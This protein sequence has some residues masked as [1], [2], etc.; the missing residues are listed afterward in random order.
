MLEKHFGISQGVL[1]LYDGSR[2]CFVPRAYTGLD[3][4]TRHRMLIPRTF[5]ED[6][7][8]LTKPGA[9]S[10]EKAPFLRPFFSIRQWSAVQS[11]SWI[12]LYYR[13]YCY[14][15]LL[16][17]EAEGMGQQR[18]QRGLEK[19][20]K[21]CSPR[22]F[23][24]RVAPLMKLKSPDK[25]RIRDM[26]G[27]AQDLEELAAESYTLLC[28][29]TECVALLQEN[30]VESEPYQCKNDILEVISSMTGSAVSVLDLP[31]MQILLIYPDGFPAKPP[32]LLHQF[33]LALERFFKKEGFKL[34]LGETANAYSPG[35]LDKH[36]IFQNLYQ[37]DRGE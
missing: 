22:V 15:L 21:G 23:L 26:K 11:L 37:D 16:V 7:R 19:C 25:P 4:T 32:L 28:D 24:S 6:N 2:E 34:R 5:L 31:G 18:F 29:C 8:V 10:R 35:S 9:S 12:P 1:L 36:E 27:N 17:W 20:I 13:A 3:T 33:S 14:G 30:G